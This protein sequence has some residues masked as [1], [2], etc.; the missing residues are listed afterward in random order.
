MHVNDVPK[1]LTGSS[2]GTVSVWNLGADVPAAEAT[3][4]ASGK[5]THIEV[6]DST[7]LWA[8]DEVSAVNE[9]LTVGTVH[10]LNNSDLSTT[11]V[12]RS[13]DMP[14]TSAFGEIRAFLVAMVEGVT[15]LVTGGA[16]AVIRTWK[17]D[18][19]TS[20]FEALSALEGHIRPVTA[21]LLHDTYLWSGSMD[22]CVRVWDLATGR[23]LGVLSAANH[24]PGHSAAVSCL[25]LI[26]ASAANAET[27][28][29]SGGAD[30]E[31][32]LWRPNGEFVHSVTHQSP[33]TAMSVFQDGY[34]GVQSLIIGLADGWI[35]VRACS[36]MALIFSLDSTL[37]KTRTVWGIQFLGK[38]C[39]AVAG[40]D[41]QLIVWKV[42]CALP[43]KA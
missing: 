42:D 6:K 43:D 11:A 33:I 39:F 13:E 17:F 30:S 40:E 4:K 26:P 29:A 5:V 1:I 35:N 21:L 23:C 18:P 8:V 38:S 36:T 37:Y 15:Y 31:L 7:I 41:G 28:M 10:L 2:D 34:N 16:C 14:Y 32:K 19:V 3:L 25:C 27:F 12:R 24:G 22:A 20:K 9:Q